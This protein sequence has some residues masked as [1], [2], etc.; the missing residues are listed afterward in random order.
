VWFLG[1]LAIF[2]ATAE[3]TRGAFGLID[4]VIPAGFQSPYHVHHAEDESFYVTEGEVTFICDG[5]KLQVGP[6]AFVFGPRDI[7]HGFRVEG[8]APARMLFLTSPGGGFERF[9]LEM[10]E[11]ATS[12]TLPPPSLP[13]MQKLMMLA[14]KYKI[15]ILGP[16]PS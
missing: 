8:T 15:D 11:P 1:T 9:I 7:P 6:G 16:L 14:A 13:D 3:S 5:K 12:A 10:G 2:K 4:S